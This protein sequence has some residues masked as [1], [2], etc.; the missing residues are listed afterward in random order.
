VWPHHAPW[1]TH[2]WNSQKFFSAS[3]GISFN[4]AILSREDMTVIP[5]FAAR[6]YAVISSYLSL[7]LSVFPFV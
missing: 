4:P 7:S 2:W 3:S 6:P 5:K 1:L